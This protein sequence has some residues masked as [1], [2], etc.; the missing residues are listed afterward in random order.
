MRRGM[1]AAH[2]TRPDNPVFCFWQILTAPG[3]HVVN[4]IHEAPAQIG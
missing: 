3:F 2:P 1:A 4:H